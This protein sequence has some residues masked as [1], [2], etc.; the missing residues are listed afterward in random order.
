MP[1]VFAHLG[2]WYISLPIYLGPMLALLAVIK[3]SDARRR[4]RGD[5]D[6]GA[7]D[8]DPEDGG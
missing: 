3:I 1:T 2:H 4:R 5:P 6:P 7:A 8:R